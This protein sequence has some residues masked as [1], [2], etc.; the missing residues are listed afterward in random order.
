MTSLSKEYEYAV[1]RKTLN[2]T[3]LKNKLFLFL[4]DTQGL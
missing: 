1:R 4:R 2:C 3:D